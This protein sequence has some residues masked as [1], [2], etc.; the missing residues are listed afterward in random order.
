MTVLAKQL[1]DSL[2]SSECSLLLQFK[3]IL[4]D[5]TKATMVPVFL[6]VAHIFSS[7]LGT[8]SREDQGFCLFAHLKLPVMSASS[9]ISR[10]C[11][12]NIHLVW[13]LCL[14]LCLSRILYIVTMPNIFCYLQLQIMTVTL[15]I[16][17][18][19]LSQ[20]VKAVLPLFIY[21]GLF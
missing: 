16:L 4:E 17:R 21:R 1:D 7:S 8:N 13:T 10:L 5:G 9:V 2:S 12:S 18:F 15:I 14:H 19:Y 11:W 3:T 6:G 20:F